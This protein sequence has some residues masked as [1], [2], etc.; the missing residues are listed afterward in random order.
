VAPT[1]QQATKIELHQILV[2]NQELLSR[3][4]S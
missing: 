1:P 3:R 4:T 2:P